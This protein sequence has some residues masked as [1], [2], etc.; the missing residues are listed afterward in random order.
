MLLAL[1]FVEPDNVI[2]AFE[3]LT[4]SDQYLDEVMLIANFFEDT[5]IGRPQR[6]D[7][8]LHRAFQQTCGASHQSIYR[9]IEFLKKHQA[10]QNCDAVQLLMG[11]PGNSK[12][13]KY[14]TISHRIKTFELKL[15]LVW[16][17]LF[18]RNKWSRR[19]SSRAN[20]SGASCPGASCLRANCW[21]KLS[22]SKLFGV[23]C[24]GRDF[25]GELSG[26]ELSTSHHGHSC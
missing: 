24:G 14:Q 7:R 22:R 16:S 26:G 23:S 10:A 19:S 13:L 11:N 18:D 20:C 25:R 5:Y 3:K 6:R 21:S 15:A 1:A 12:N 4:E 17:F 8:R 2:Q 9:F